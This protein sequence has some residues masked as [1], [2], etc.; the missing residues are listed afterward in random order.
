MDDERNEDLN[1]HGDDIEE[2]IRKMMDPNEPEG[3]VSKPKE[4]SKPEPEPEESAETLSAPE[5]PPSEKP[6]KGKKIIPIEQDTK[7]TAKADKEETAPEVK[8]ITIADDTESPADVAE[9]LDAA[10]AGL[11]EPSASI[12]DKTPQLVKAAKKEPLSP[13]PEPANA[14]EKAEVPVAD[15]EPEEPIDEPAV[16][17]DPKTDQAVD[18]IVAAESD[19]LLEI[20]DAVRDTD[21][22]VKAPAKPRR[23][24]GQLLKAA[25]SHKSVRWLL[26]LLLIGGLLAAGIFPRSRY[27]LLNTAGVRAESSLTVLDN[28]TQ[29]PLKNVQVS[30][31]GASGL[32]DGSGKAQLK[33]VKLGHTTLTVEKRAFATAT[34]SVTV[35]WGSNPLA[36]IS[37]TP[38][39]TQYSFTVTD[40]LSG[41]PVAHVE[42]SSG[43]ASALS[44]D[45][46]M[47][48]L[49]LDKPE[50][51]FTVT[52][53]GDGFRDE[54]LTLNV[55]DKADHA[56][57]LVPARKQLF[58][59]KRTGKYD[60]YSVY[61]DG[62]DE[63]LVLAGSGSERDDMVI[64][65]HPTAHVA[66]YVSTRGNQHNSD[67]YLLSNLI[68]INTDDNSTTNVTASERIQVVDWS[69]DKLVYVQIAA[70]ASANNP[71]RYRLM[72][73]DYQTQTN[74]ELAASNFFN[75]VVAVNG[76][77]YY[78][79]S[80]AYQSS[81]TGLYRVN[82]DG[83]NQT[84]VFDQEVWN[85]IRTSYDH[86]ALSVQQQWYD[87]RI[88]DKT[89][90]KLN[91]AP[92]NQVPRV[93]IE[94]PDGK[95]SA[96]IDTR[97][98]KGVLLIYDPNSKEEKTLTSQNGLT[99][100]VTWLSNSVLI[101]RIKN[102]Q[103]TADYAVSLD[104]GNPVKV[105]DVTNTGGIDRWYYY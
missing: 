23:S 89:P 46:G 24:L 71:K 98:G 55:A 100:P 86:L 30:L 18:E 59:S 90:S 66:A 101:Y 68:L 77:V 75:D 34:K 58:I 36:D 62:K 63:K 15:T 35:G 104:G 12:A 64:V 51:T 102:A 94:S 39:G 38:T 69:G 54:T 5:L 14:P 99:Y 73:Y 33:H 105:R 50:D 103:E 48:K 74:K 79:P 70:G 29:L 43:E 67:N 26:L 92:A 4:E 37:L 44:D 8:Q 95:H 61:I 91:S 65:T 17:K 40:F 60:L 31:G 27:F 83:S 42:A 81:K 80:S 82:P 49:T 87:Y 10:I 13:V 45:K 16:L 20:E 7:K 22:P 53:K 78:A 32:T 52:L 57:K 96:W 76:A 85:I 6:S 11:D 41:K 25:W 2:K 19:E 28:S 72:S 93:Y 9:K 84:T 47:I 21:E 88:G 1:P 3:E 97:D 56:V